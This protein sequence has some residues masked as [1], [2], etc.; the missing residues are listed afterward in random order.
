MAEKVGSF[1]WFRDLEYRER[2]A[3]DQNANELDQMEGDVAALGKLV[4]KQADD[5]V[6][7]RAFVIGLVEVLHTKTSLDQAELDAAVSDAYARLT[8]PPPPPDPNVSKPKPRARD[9]RPITCAKCGKS[10]P[11]YRTTITGDG[12]VCDACAA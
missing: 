12:E 9:E 1:S 8:A 11:A 7:L 4:R 2:D 6:V 3:I 10:V 5:L